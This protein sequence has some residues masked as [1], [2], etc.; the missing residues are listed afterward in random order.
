MV[1]N[2]NLLFESE[3]WFING[4]FSCCPNLFVQTQLYTIH[5]I[6]LS[7]IVPLV[8]N[9]SNSMFKTDQYCDL[10]NNECS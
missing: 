4:T 9:N 3:Y 6:I 7:N 5:S 1:K 2:L 10:K 8:N